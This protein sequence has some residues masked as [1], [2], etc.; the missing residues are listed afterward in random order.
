MARQKLLIFDCDGVLVDSEP[1]SI[2]VL[3]ET[4]HDLGVPMT[5]AECYH[6]FLGRSL[7][8]MKTTL[9]DAYGRTLTD[10][11]LAAMR[12]R[13]YTLYRA[14]LKPIVGIARA[15]DAIDL[16]CCVASSSLPDRIKL[17]LGLTGLTHYFGAH[18]FSATMVAN[19][20]PAPDL[21]LLASQR[22]SEAPEN[23][24]V[25]EDSPAGIEAAHRAGMRA[26]AF[27]GG[28]HSGPAGLRETVA[29]MHP[30][31]IF[32]RMEDLPAL[33]ETLPMG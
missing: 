13:L 25:I 28:S 19:G 3:M 11:Q 18:V 7:S 33:I 23:C 4:M 22:M 6:H 16:P 21:F 5:A 17:S 30:Y 14:E 2:R 31:C 24:I 15:L 10:H 12:E 32:E 27:V 20:K 29:A 8:S 9:S 1:L 26:L